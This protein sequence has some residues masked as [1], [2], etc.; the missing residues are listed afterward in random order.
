V[1]AASRHIE[2]FLMQ[3]AVA[4]HDD[5]AAQDFS[6][7][8]EVRVLVGFEQTRDLRV[9]GGHVDPEPERLRGSGRVWRANWTTEDRRECEFR[10]PDRMLLASSTHRDRTGS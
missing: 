4:F 5:R 2:F 8:L 10:A 7:L 3:L 1:K 6:D 9:D